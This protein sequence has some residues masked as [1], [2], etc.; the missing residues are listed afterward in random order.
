MN[1][2]ERGSII[3]G[4]FFIIYLALEI[5]RELPPMIRVE[6]SRLLSFVIALQASNYCPEVSSLGAKIKPDTGYLPS[7]DYLLNNY[8]P[9]GWM[10]HGLEM[11][12]GMFQY[13]YI[14]SNK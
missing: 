10:S 12:H 8:C 3:I 13:I 1:Y 2:R 9:I 11:K 4:F 14:L 7:V 6:P 5:F